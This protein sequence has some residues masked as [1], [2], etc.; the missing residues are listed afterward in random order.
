MRAPASAHHGRDCSA[1]VGCER[2]IQIAARAH[3]VL[4]CQAGTGTVLSSW[5]SRSATRRCSACSA[6]VASPAQP[7]LMASISAPTPTGG[8]REGSDPLAESLRSGH[9]QSSK[10]KVWGRWITVCRADCALPASQHSFVT[11][12]A[13]TLL[14]SI[15]PCG[16]TRA[17]SQQWARAAPSREHTL[18][19]HARTAWGAALAS[20]R[21]RLRG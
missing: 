11:C 2:S 21:T 6:A 1:V 5:R 3:L 10:Q 19:R 12:G 20:P 9:P 4:A 18:T 16:N 14:K 13:P 15:P 8:S 7:A 17:R